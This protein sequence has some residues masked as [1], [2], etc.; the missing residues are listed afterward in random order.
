MDESLQKHAGYGFRYLPMSA[1]LW[2]VK[3]LD[4][5]SFLCIF[6]KIN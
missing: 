1:E 4:L 2:E 5:S 3:Y 6:E